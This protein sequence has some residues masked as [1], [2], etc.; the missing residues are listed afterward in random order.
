[1]RDCEIHGTRKY[2]LFNIAR[3]EACEAG[4]PGKN[5]TFGTLRDLLLRAM[6]HFGAPQSWLVMKHYALASAAT[7]PD[8]FLFRVEFNPL[9]P[10]M[11]I[12]NRTPSLPESGFAD[13]CGIRKSTREGDGY[14][15]TADEWRLVLDP[16]SAFSANGKWWAGLV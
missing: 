6:V 15:C 13:I 11:W 12:V 5:D 3:C 14:V 9:D 4:V 10:D 7:P 16:Y 1:M 2:V 8:D